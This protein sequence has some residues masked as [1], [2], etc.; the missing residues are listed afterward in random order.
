[1]V[2]LINTKDIIANTI[3]IIEGNRI[4]NIKD[5]VGDNNNNNGNFDTTELLLKLDKKANITFVN[6]NV[7]YL[8]DKFDSYETIITSND[9]ISLKAN[10]SDV[11]DKNKVNNLIANIVLPSGVKGDAGIAGKQGIQWIK[12]DT[13]I[14]GLQG[15]KGDAG[16]AG[17]Q[18]IKGDA[19]I[20]GPQG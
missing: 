1:M 3:S 15:V 14:A 16:I 2:S 11:Y 19:G 5:L 20:A 17:L 18:G 13:G 6:S 4:I 10:V 7:K 8:S 9:K 12:G